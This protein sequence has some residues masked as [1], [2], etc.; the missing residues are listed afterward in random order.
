MAG[1]ERRT[2]LQIGRSVTLN[3]SGAGTVSLGPS[4]AMG[5]A[6]WHVDGVILQTSRPGQA[7][8][9]RAVVYLNDSTANNSQGLSYDGSFAQGSCDIQLTRGQQLV[10]AWTGGQAGDIATLTLTGEKVG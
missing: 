3:A 7:P 2:V 1:Q 10:C 5:P 8:I 6:I 4:S 9:P